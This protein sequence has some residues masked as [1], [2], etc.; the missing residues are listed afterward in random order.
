M[1]DKASEVISG[2]GP[3]G[4]DTN[5]PNLHSERRRKQLDVDILPTGGIGL[6][7]FERGDSATVG[8]KNEQPWHRMAAY[9]LNVGRTNS[10]IAMAAGV[11]VSAVSQLRAN[12]WFQELCAVIANTEGEEVVGAIKSEALASVNTLVQLR[13][14]SENDQVKLSA[15]RTIIEHAQ[16]K[17]IA[18]IVSASSHTTY[19]SPEDEYNA[20][21]TELAALTASQNKKKEE[22]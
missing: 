8:R 17:P 3:K 21:Q 15:A 2:V 4:G 5:N 19:A 7:R 9:M 1:L 13:D 6:H 12:K 22:N 18:R 16:G 20:L 11:T 14:F 10:E